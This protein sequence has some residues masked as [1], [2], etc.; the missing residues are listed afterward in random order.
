MSPPKTLLNP[1]VFVSYIPKSEVLTGIVELGAGGDGGFACAA[2]AATVELGAGVMEVL[3]VQV[4][5]LG[6]RQLQ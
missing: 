5:Q 4:L 2:G 6:K 3:L 1:K